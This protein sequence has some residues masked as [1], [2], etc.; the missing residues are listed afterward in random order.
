MFGITP[1]YTPVNSQESITSYMDNT[2][3]GPVEKRVIR[4]E[5]PY[6]NLHS[7]MS[8]RNPGTNRADTTFTTPSG[9]RYDMNDVRSGKAPSGYGYKFFRKPAGYFQQ[10]GNIENK[11]AALIA[12]FVIRYLKG[13]GVP[14]EN[15][16]SSDGSLNQE[17]VPAVQ[18]VLAEIG[19]SAEFWSMYE[20]NP[21]EV[22]SQ[23]IQSKN[24]GAAQMARK[25]AKLKRLSQLRIYKK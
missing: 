25:G 16:I 20:Q 24:P 23:Y 13:L 1:D 15:I 6:A 19:D 12:D 4:K 14:E 8:I 17:H 2:H 7:T 3:K 11:Q 5:V 9:T 10:G 22:I 21:D 18:E